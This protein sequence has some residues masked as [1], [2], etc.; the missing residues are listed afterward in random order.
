MMRMMVIATTTS[1]CTRTSTTNT[2][3]VGKVDVN[4]VL[5]GGNQSN[6]ESYSSGNSDCDGMSN[7]GSD[8]EAG[9]GDIDDETTPNSL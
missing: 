7:G 3:T 6:Y 2:N 8:S 1:C 4:I 9:I 5:D